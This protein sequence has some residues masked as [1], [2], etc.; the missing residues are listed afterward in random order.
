MDTTYFVWHDGDKKYP[1][2]RKLLD[3]LAAYERKARIP[4]EEILVN[5]ADKELPSPVPSKVAPFVKRN[6]FYIPYPAD[7]SPRWT[8]SPT[9]KR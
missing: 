4:A 8:A 3:A 7:W 5:E 6:Y 1:Q 9:K 2:P